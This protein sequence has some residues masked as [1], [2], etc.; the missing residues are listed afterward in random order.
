M[1]SNLLYD[2]GQALAKHKKYITDVVWWGSELF[3]LPLNKLGTM[4]DIPYNPF[5]FK[6]PL[7]VAGHNWYIKFNT[8]KC[9]FDYVDCYEKPSKFCDT[10]L[11]LT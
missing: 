11:K 1:H 4:A 6:M 3:E 8:D 2:I 7:I 5:H 9:L 10:L